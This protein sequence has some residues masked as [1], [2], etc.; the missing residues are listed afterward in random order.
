MPLLAA[1]KKALRVSKTK[2]S[3]NAKVRSKLE[4]ITKKVIK[5]IKLGEMAL[6]EQQISQAYKTIDKAAKK[7]II[8]PNKGAHIKSKLASAISSAESTTSSK[9]AAKKTTAKKSNKPAAHVKITP[10]NS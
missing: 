6:A 9:P 8:H 1:S 2:T 3:Q 5:L 4:R 10:K 7:G